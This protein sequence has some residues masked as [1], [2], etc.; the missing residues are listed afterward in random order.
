MPLTGPFMT[1]NYSGKTGSSAVELAGGPIQDVRSPVG[2]AKF[3]GGKVVIL[4]RFCKGYYFDE[5]L[6]VSAFR[7]PSSLKGLVEDA[8][9][10]LLVG[11]EG[12]ARTSGRYLHRLH[13]LAVQSSRILKHKSLCPPTR[14]F[15]AQL[16]IVV[17][18]KLLT[19]QSGL[20]IL[21]PYFLHSKEDRT[22]SGS[23]TLHFGPQPDRR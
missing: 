17:A 19:L 6:A 4:V 21:G 14:P 11:V 9:D 16:L 20:S 13:A 7:F 2:D 8:A 3:Q 15:S 10:R 18:K 12:T 23:K 1:E 22:Q 5:R